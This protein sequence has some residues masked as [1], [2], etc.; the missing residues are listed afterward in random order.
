MTADC[1]VSR[2][3]LLF[4]EQHPP[5]L[6]ALPK[7]SQQESPFRAICPYLSFTFSLILCESS[8]LYVSQGNYIS[9]Q[10]KLGKVS[11]I[12]ETEAKSKGLKPPK[13]ERFFLC[14]K[15]PAALK[16]MMLSCL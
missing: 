6:S 12:M 10:E 4:T 13:K 2:N 5:S 9:Y 3:P 1:E 11:V 8:I 15:N 16:V 7:G 14:S